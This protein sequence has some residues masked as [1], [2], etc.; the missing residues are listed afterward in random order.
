MRMKSRFVG[1]R[2][3]KQARNRVRDWSLQRNA[4]ACQFPYTVVFSKRV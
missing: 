1:H 3:L 4:T 2:F